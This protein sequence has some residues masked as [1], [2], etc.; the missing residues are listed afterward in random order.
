MICSSYNTQKA[1]WQE[2]GK[3]KGREKKIKRKKG[4]GRRSENNEVIE[5][6]DRKIVK[7]EYGIVK[8]GT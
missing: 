3:I 7:E 2:F 6:Y 4:E 1:S 8:R 5:R